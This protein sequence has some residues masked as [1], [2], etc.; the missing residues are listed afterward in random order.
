MPQNT[1]EAAMPAPRKNRRG[2]KRAGHPPPG[3]KKRS[4]VEVNRLLDVCEEMVLLGMPRH[5]IRAALGQAAGLPGPMSTK[6]TEVYIA[7]VAQRHRDNP[8][9]G[10]TEAREAA[11]RRY[12]RMIAELRTTIGRFAQLPDGRV[13]YADM[14]LK[15]ENA[16]LSWENRLAALRGMDAPRDK[17]AIEAAALVIV[18]DKLNRAIQE[19]EQAATLREDEEARRQRELEA[20]DVPAGPAEGNGNGTG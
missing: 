7:R 17:E 6:T 4:R 14:I 20:I 9:P 1:A 16:V 13:K 5:R 2:G 8:L 15:Y 11:E 19:K 12:Q 18:M 3:G 10:L